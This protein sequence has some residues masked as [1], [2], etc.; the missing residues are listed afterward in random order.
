[1]SR[2]SRPLP[3]EAAA[4]DAAVGPPDRPPSVDALA[5]ELADTS[6]LPHPLLVEAARRAI[7]AGRPAAA[8]DMAAETERLLLRRVIN[9]TG[10]LLHTNLGRAPLNPLGPAATRYANLELDLGTG[11]RAQRAPAIGLAL[12]TLTGCEDALVV[13]NGAAAILLVLSA[14]A[15]GHRVVVSRGELVEIGGGFRI[16][17]ILRLSRAQLVEVGTT[18]ITRTAD[19]VDALGQRGEGDPGSMVLVVHQANFSITG[20][21]ERPSVAD[22]AALGWPLVADLGS[23]LLDATTPWLPGGPPAWLASEPAARQTL[24]AGAQLVTFSGDKLLGGPQAGIIAGASDLV[25]RCA[26]HPLARAF[27]PGGTVLASMQATLLAYLERD[28]DSLPF[29]RMATASLD[30]LRDR[31]DRVGHGT[32]AA[33]TSCRSV[34]GGGSAPGGQID[35]VGLSLPGD[36]SA[37]LRETDPPVLSHVRDDVTVLDLRTVDPSEDDELAAILRRVAPR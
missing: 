4:P 20:F 9:A 11:E 30:E 3:K 13:N 24:A 32:A 36:V 25:R 23:G 18:N 35:S 7:A 27:R 14:L 10:V 31:A 15:E 28:L 19:Y 5:R 26:R 33:I 2:R 1:M 22:L 37:Q 21:T 17:D 34:P 29:W 8:S 6:R 12:R 16:P